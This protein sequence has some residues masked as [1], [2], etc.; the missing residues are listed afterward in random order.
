MNF[1]HIAQHM[2]ESLGIRHD[3]GARLDNT[4]TAALARQL[5]HIFATV[6][7]IKYPANM[8]LQFCPLETGVPAGADSFTHRVR[9]EVRDAALIADYASDLPQVDVIMYEESQRIFS[10][11]DSY[12]YSVQDLHRA[13]MG[14]RLDTDRAAVARRAIDTKIDRI[15]A[16]GDSTV[17]VVGMLNDDTNV[18]D[19]TVANGSWTSGATPAEILE[20]L[21]A[22]QSEIVSESHGLF[23]PDTLLLPTAHYEH[24]ANTEYS[25]NSDR[26][27]LEQ[28][29]ASSPYI[30][31]VAPWYLCNTADSGTN[32]RGMMY[33]KRPETLKAIIPVVFEQLP[34]QA[35]N[36]AYM[37][38]CHARVG[39]VTFREPVAC[40]Y[41][42]GI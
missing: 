23:A 26:T 9:D 38:P 22:V 32:P 24:I 25:A 35:K 12:Q 2:I 33:P 8:A 37:V 40:R 17:N 13:A 14:V 18:E 29:L 27:I 19:V 16:L 28:F 10:I 5:E 1:R 15:I 11:G 3:D 21:R 42:D 6:Q 7:D 30:K 4:Q 41:L 20:D 39:G 34:P 31:T 36:L